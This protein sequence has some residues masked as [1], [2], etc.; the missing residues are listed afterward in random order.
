MQARSERVTIARIL[1]N[2]WDKYSQVFISIEDSHAFQ[3]FMFCSNLYAFLKLYLLS[4]FFCCQLRKCPSLPGLSHNFLQNLAFQLSPRSLT[5]SISPFLYVLFMYFTSYSYKY[6]SVSQ[7]LKRA[8]M[9]T[10]CLLSYLI[11]IPNKIP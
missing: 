8:F 11:S 6:A 9:C 1:I 5:A 10:F 3:P 2:I 7:I 4:S